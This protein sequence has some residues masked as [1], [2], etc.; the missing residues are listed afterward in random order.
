MKYQE[1]QFKY[2]EKHT[3]KHLILTWQEITLN[4][5]SKNSGTS[6]VTHT[7]SENRLNDKHIS[8][9]QQV[10]QWATPPERKYKRNTET[11][12]SV[13]TCREWKVSFQ[14]KL[15]H[16]IEGRK[17]EKKKEVTKD[18]AGKSTIENTNDKRGI[19]FNCSKYQ[20]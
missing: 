7:G 17:R 3:T 15:L 12:P 4:T 10:L 14:E 1:I 16:W 19:Y 9:I 20:A 8:S 5:P 2:R 18:T 11:M 13:I 6:I